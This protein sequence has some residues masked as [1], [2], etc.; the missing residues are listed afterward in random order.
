[1]KVTGARREDDGSV[2]LFLDEPTEE[3]V[4]VSPEQ[5]CDLMASVSPLGE[6]PATRIAARRFHG[7]WVQ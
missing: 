5:W 1:M 3:P 7:M 2:S 6:T 4:A